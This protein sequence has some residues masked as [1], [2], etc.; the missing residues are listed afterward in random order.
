M[1]RAELWGWIQRLFAVAAMYLPALLTWCRR[2]GHWLIYAWFQLALWLAFGL[3]LSTG[4]GTAFRNGGNP[5]AAGPA[6]RPC[7]ARGGRARLT[8]ATAAFS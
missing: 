3:R 6:V 1:G 4:V 7:R 2:L 5:V 8:P